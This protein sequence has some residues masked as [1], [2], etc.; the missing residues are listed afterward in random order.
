MEHF[1]AFQDAAVKG[2]LGRLRRAEV[3]LRDRI[4]ARGEAA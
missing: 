1:A 3:D 4:D 2:R